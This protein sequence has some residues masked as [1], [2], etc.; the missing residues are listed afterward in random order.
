MEKKKP[1][2]NEP[3]SR[4]YDRHPKTPTDNNS[5]KVLPV[6]N[7]TDNKQQQ[8]E[9]CLNFVILTKRKNNRNY[10]NNLVFYGFQFQMIHICL[11]MEFFFCG[12]NSNFVILQLQEKN[13]IFNKF[14]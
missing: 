6:A 1:K 11:L 9:Y 7:G 2:K 8:Q 14:A 3:N 12:C 5:R 13:I 4:S 10:C